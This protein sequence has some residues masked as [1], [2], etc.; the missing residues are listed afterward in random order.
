MT[1]M[2]RDAI[3]DHTQATLSLYFCE[4]LLIVGGGAFSRSIAAVVGGD[5]LT[6]WPALVL[7]IF[8][9]ALCPPIAQAAD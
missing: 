1:I 2:R 8:T 9:V 6:A 7:V 5:T 3:A 4:M